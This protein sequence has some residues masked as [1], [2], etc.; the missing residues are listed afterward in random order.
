M[1]AATP[2]LLMG[3][4]LGIA[5]GVQR[6]RRG[7]THAEALLDAMHRQDWPAARA[8]LWFN[9]IYA[10]HEG[11]RNAR[12]WGPD[13]VL[14]RSDAGGSGARPGDCVYRVTGRD[15]ESREFHF[16]FSE[17]GRVALLEVEGRL[18]FFLE[19]AQTSQPTTLEVEK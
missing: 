1:L 11:T 16:Q 2:L 18:A 9:Q 13:W 14:V 5:R 17:D 3:A 6:D 15:G 4:V 10:D 8:Q 19:R 12:I 7:E